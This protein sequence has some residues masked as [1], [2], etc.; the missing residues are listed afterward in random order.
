MNWMAV[1]RIALVLTAVWFVSL[2]TGE[3]P[4]AGFGDRTTNQTAKSPG[5]H[6]R[7]EVNSVEGKDVTIAHAVRLS[8]LRND[9]GSLFITQ[10][11]SDLYTGGSVQNKDWTVLNKDTYTYDWKAKS[12]PRACA[13]SCH[14]VR[15]CPLFAVSCDVASSSVPWWLIRSSCSEQNYSPNLTTWCLKLVD[16]WLL[17]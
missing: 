9:L 3:S 6:S 15:N 4:N 8:P 2:P 13:H 1:K 12:I 7:K 5:G 11:Q 17:S 14:V 10:V 16:E